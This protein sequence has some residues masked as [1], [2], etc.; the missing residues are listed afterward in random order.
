MRA[1]N[2]RKSDV[3]DINFS[4][5]V[6]HRQAS[7]AF[8]ESENRK[9]KHVQKQAYFGEMTMIATSEENRSEGAIL[10]GS[11]KSKRYVLLSFEQLFRERFGLKNEFTHG[12]RNCECQNL[13]S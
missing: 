12:K 11:K 9:Y 1:E 4:Q 10:S 2:E 7:E 6:A 8:S 13:S 3:S 5:K